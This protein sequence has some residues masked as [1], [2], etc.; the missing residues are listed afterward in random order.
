MIKW[1][2]IVDNSIIS[3]RQSR[4]RL[5][6]GLEVTSYELRLFLQW[7]DITAFYVGVRSFQSG[8]R[9]REYP[10]S[11]LKKQVNLSS[12][13][14]FSAFY[15]ARKPDLRDFQQAAS[16]RQIVECLCDSSVRRRIAIDDPH[17]RQR[18]RPR[19][20]PL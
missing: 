10:S 9:S 12:L 16:L 6:R 5:L 3:S 7:R 2:L 17:R 11:L 15:Q 1:L 14:V 19:K 20:V 4:K 18:P 13:T 8:N